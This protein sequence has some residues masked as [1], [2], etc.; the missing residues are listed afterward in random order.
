MA[1]AAEAVTG[2][3]T[4]AAQVV[5][6]ARTQVFEA[7][8]QFNAQLAQLKTEL[9]ARDAALALA[10]EREKMLNARLEECMRELEVLRGNLL[11]Q[12]PNQNDAESIESHPENRILNT[13]NILFFAKE[14]QKNQLSNIDFFDFQINWKTIG[15][16][17]PKSI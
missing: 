2:A 1:N 5:L 8:A 12:V 9:N 10:G 16:R 11:N 3:R 6:D 7:N 14:N 4:E 15:K 13:I 17:G